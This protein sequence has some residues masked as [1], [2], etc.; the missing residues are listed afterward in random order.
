MSR[1]KAKL[2][3]WLSIQPARSAWCHTCHRH[4]NAIAWSK[5]RFKVYAVP[6]YVYLDVAEV[7]GP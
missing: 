5:C 1:H 3:T 2:R 6:A 7:F 4:H